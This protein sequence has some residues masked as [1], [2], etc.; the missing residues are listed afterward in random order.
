VRGLAI[1]VVL[2]LLCVS[3]SA[4]ASVRAGGVYR[5]GVA[6]SFT[7]TDDF[8]PT[9]ESYFLGEAIQNQLLVRT[10]VGYDHVSGAMGFRL[11]PDLATAV[12]S[13][14]DGGKTYTF[15]LKAGVRFGPPVDRAV[16][17]R[18]VLYAL[19][20]LANPKDGGEQAILFRRIV[21]WDAY[22]AGK[23]GTI[24]GI[25]TPNASTIVFHLTQRMG[26][27]LYQLT[28]PAAGPIPREV[29][30]CFEGK[31]GAYGRDLVSTGPYMIEGADKVD[32]SSCSKLKPMSGYDGQ[33]SLTLVRNPSYEPATDSKAARQNLPDEFRFTVDSNVLDV[34][35]KV[36]AGQLDDE[37]SLAM[38]PQDLERY[39]RDP[40][41]RRFLKVEPDLATDWVTMNLTQP[42]FDDVHVRRALSWVLDKTALR[43]AAGG[44]LAG[45]VA[46]GIVPDVLFGGALS[47]FDPYRTAGSHGSVA[48][49]KAA[50]RGSKYDTQGDGMCG[51]AMC[52][53]VLLLTD[54]SASAPG[55]AAVLQ[56]DAARIG[57]TFTVRSINGPYPVIQTVRKQIPIADFVG[58]GT[59][60]PDPAG[61]LGPDFDSRSIMPVGNVDLPLIG[62]TPAQCKAMH[63]TGDCAPYDPKTGLG[64]PSVNGM[65]DRCGV[66]VGGPRRSCWVAVERYLMTQGVPVIPYLWPSVQHIIGRNVT[67]W[68]YDAS[69]DMTSFVHVAVR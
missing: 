2:A 22:A 23:A 21:G 1:V 43:Q 4:G 31:P 5:V 62:V 42:P 37:V 7:F 53:N 39:N 44:P 49:A 35:Q 48:R 34:V 28:L 25:S 65:L 66:L 33:T 30:R 17:S 14:T 67:R 50:M 11:V 47:G 8:D 6:P 59:G 68:V 3:G 46:A 38:P 18:D 32:P 69:G 13:P 54:T 16:T 19:E 57:I 41:L 12:P 36:E 55:I 64:V 27:F 51:A 58:W 52:K 20:R 63:I 10:L 40:K 45:K 9:G 61:M 24:S 56:Q 29:A 60:E 15:H 26:D